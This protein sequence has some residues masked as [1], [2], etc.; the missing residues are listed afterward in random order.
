MSV[1]IKGM[2][3]LLSAHYQ[4]IIINETEENINVKVTPN[5]LYSV[6]V[7][8]KA[9][10]HT[11]YS[12]LSDIEKIKE[13]ID[14]YLRN[15]TIFVIQ[16]NGRLKHRPNKYFAANAY[17]T[18]IDGLTPISRAL[19]LKLINEELKDEYKKVIKKY[20]EDR[21]RHF[22]DI[23][24][25]KKIDIRVDTKRSSYIIEDET[26]YISLLANIN[27][28]EK[29]SSSVK[30]LRKEAEF[31]KM[32][33]LEFFIRANSLINGTLYGD[34]TVE[35]FDSK[36]KRT[37]IMDERLMEYL[38]EARNSYSKYSK[39][40]DTISIDEYLESIEENKILQKK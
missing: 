20:E 11:N 27:I 40:L 3:N 1:K 25:C 38:K 24:N 13:I 23:M 36:E 8:D 34:F 29:W 12:T 37:I 2:V 18:M 39:E 35:L 33:L 9:Y 32:I 22:D 19:Y 7:L 28:G 10:Y 6:K 17:E 31:F 26:A 16:T 5:N 14:S 15:N 21:I 4:D 30:L